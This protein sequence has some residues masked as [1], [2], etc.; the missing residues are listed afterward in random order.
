MQNSIP[1]FLLN[2]Y[3]YFASC[4]LH[5]KSIIHNE[6]VTR[7]VHLFIKWSLERCIMIPCEIRIG[8][9]VNSSFVRA[10]GFEADETCKLNCI[11]GEEML[12]L[13]HY[14]NLKV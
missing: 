6:V 7:T 12:I 13:V 11:V 9:V 14:T 8:V 2:N 5:N 10:S 4:S 3:N 1:V